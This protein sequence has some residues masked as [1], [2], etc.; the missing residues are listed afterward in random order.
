LQVEV[1]AKYIK[2]MLNEP[3]LQLNAA[4]N[5]WI[6]GILLF[7][8]TLI[9]VPATKHVG[10]DTLSR[11]P[12][13]DGEQIDDDDDEWLDDIALLIRTVESKSPLP[14]FTMISKSDKNLL[15]IYHF[16]TTLEAPNHSTSQE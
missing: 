9:H 13:G 2:G 12:L 8:F 10:F 3:V 11:R 15:D 4:I 14:A 1:D 7:N 16:F 5:R 6:Q